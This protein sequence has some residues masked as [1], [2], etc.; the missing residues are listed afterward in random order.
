MKCDEKI[1][2][3]DQ[4]LTCSLIKHPDYYYHV[5]QGRI[6]YND[7]PA[8]MYSLYDMVMWTRTSGYYNAQGEGHE[9]TSIFT[10]DPD[11]LRIEQAK[12]TQ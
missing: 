4:E 7:K 6:D 9:V 12:A 11:K 10:I 3:E 2:Y 5:Y 1:T 8:A